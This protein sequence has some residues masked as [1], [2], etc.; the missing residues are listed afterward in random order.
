MV[1]GLKSSG[2]SQ[3]LFSIYADRGQ[4][5]IE[6][7]TLVCPVGQHKLMHYRHA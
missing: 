4:L 1:G 3:F 5:H 2:L 6:P 7:G